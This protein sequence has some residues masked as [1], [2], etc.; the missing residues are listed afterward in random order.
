MIYKNQILLRSITTVLFIALL[1]PNALQF[2]HLF[3]SH[4]HIECSELTS[5][6]HEKVTDCSLCD[7]VIS[8]NDFHFDNFTYPLFAS[9]GDVLPPQYTS[10]A[11]PNSSSLY[12]LRGPPSYS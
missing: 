8:S 7:V 11:I 6:L 12:F 2:G 1:L 3:E 10:E 9:E 4:E 5:H